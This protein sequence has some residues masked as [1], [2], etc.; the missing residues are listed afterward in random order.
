MPVVLRRNCLVF[1]VVSGD[2]I[3]VCLEQAVIV[4]AA[5]FITTCI[6][7]CL[8]TKQRRECLHKTTLYST[9]VNN[10]ATSVFVTASEERLSIE[11]IQAICPQRLLGRWFLPRQKDSPTLGCRVSFILSTKSSNHG[12]LLQIASLS[13]ALG[14]VFTIRWHAQLCVNY[15]LPFLILA[16]PIVGARH[17]RVPSHTPKHTRRLT[18]AFALLH[19]TLPHISETTAFSFCFNVHDKQKEWNT[20]FCNRGLEK[21]SRPAQ[22]RC[23][24]RERRAWS[25][26]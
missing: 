15:Q 19:F 9:V 4:I 10:L 23:R 3:S 25:P 7:H 21:D 22:S 11:L 2:C 20:I 14:Y 16:Y 12:S 6:I 24:C 17:T 1:I 26:D 13:S 5:P 18:Y 8:Q